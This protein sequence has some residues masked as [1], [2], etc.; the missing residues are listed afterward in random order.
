[1]VSGTTP[2]GVPIG[3]VG[4]GA[5]AGGVDALVR[6]VGSL[7]A[8]LPVA[9]CVVLHVPATGRSLLAPILDRHSELP[10]M[11][12]K[13]DVPLRAG[14]VYVAPTDMHL[15]VAGGRLQLDHGPRENGVR[16]AVDPLL[17]SIAAQYGE[18]TVG[19]I[20]SGA[21]GD[22]SS[23]AVA[24]HEAGG[25]VIVQDPDE[26][27]VAS[28]PETA[29]LSVGRAAE[30]LG[31][32]AIGGR[33]V[34]IAHGLPPMREDVLVAPP[35]EILPGGPDRPSGP[36][37]AFTCP[38]CD[39]PLWEIDEGQGRRFQCRV[40]HAFSEDSLVVEQGTAVE[41]ALWSALEALEERAEFLTRL[42]ERFHGKP[43]LFER[44]ARAARDALD[45]AQLIRR[46]LGAR[47]EDDHALGLQAEVVE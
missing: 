13:H 11:E 35:S 32:D 7:P 29:L 31:I 10:V 19:V 9:V 16:P 33:L 20:L 30:T 24:I 42:A 1:V 26:A 22:G 45:R 44:H 40:G 21:L 34:E 36:P 18:R 37:T 5:S 39:G 8:D 3:I 38:E 43:R 27:T 6:L 17:S 23:G 41:A 28:M 2:E 47:A 12:A 4:V 15:T 46:A 25:V 14:R